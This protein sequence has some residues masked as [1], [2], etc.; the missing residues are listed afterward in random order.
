MISITFTELIVSTNSQRL[1]LGVSHALFLCA[2]LS[3]RD[4]ELTTVK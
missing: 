3:S 2:A 4:G 1:Y